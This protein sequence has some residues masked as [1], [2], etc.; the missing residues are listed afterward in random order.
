VSESSRGER[1]ATAFSDRVVLLTGASS[2]IGA[3]LAVQLA[4]AGARV[5][6]AAR[7]AERLELV[8]GKCRAAGGDVLVLPTDVSLEEDCR[9]AVE[10][11]VAHFGRLDILVNNAGLSAHGL[12]Q[13]ITDFSI[14]ERLVRVNYLGA[15]WCTAH[16][17]PHLRK[18]RGQ[19]VAVSSLTGLTGVPTRSAYGATKHAMAGFFDSLRVELRESGV[20]VT[21]IYPGFVVS[22]MSRR[23]LSPDGSPMGNGAERRH[24]RDR[25]PVDECCR[26][27][28]SAVA[29]RDRELL[30]TWR[31]RVGRI[32]KL[33]SPALL[34]RMAAR[35][36]RPRG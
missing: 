36:I 32:L 15:V 22:E 12:F 17:L 14:F 24:E 6:I 13:D 9:L 16:A 26:L 8:A 23:A 33:I 27:I 4:T 20:S 25:M 7:D 34:D 29:R 5:A 28:L 10:R 19:V 18:A 31:A 2:G 11:T 3:E 21:V 30:M 1:G 35:A